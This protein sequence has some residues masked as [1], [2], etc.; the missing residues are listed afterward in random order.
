MASK[1]FIILLYFTFLS[2]FSY[3]NAQ[4]YDEIERDI[5]DYYDN[6]LDLFE[7]KH[8]V[9]VSG[10]C[11]DLSFYYYSEEIYYLLEKLK[12]EEKN[13]NFLK[14]PQ[15]IDVKL[16]DKL[17]ICND[18][19]I[20]SKDEDYTK[21]QNISELYITNMSKSPFD[22][23]NFKNLNT[24][25]LMPA[26][27]DFGGGILIN[28]FHLNQ[29]GNLNKLQNV[30]I[31]TQKIYKIPEKIA[32]LE[33]LKILFIK[34][35]EVSPFLSL[36]LLIKDV[37]IFDEALSRSLYITDPSS[38]S[39][40]P[41]IY[42]FYSV[43]ILDTTF[44]IDNNKLNFLQLNLKT[45]QKHNTKNGDFHLNYKNGNKLTIGKFKNGKPVGE[46]KFYY[47]NGN[48]YSIRKYKD[49]KE[50]G[51]WY[52]F[53]ETGDTTLVLKF[54]KGFLTYSLE[55]MDSIYGKEKSYR[56][57]VLEYQQETPKKIKLSIYYDKHEKLMAEFIFHE[58]Y[59]TPNDYLDHFF[60]DIIRYIIWKNEHVKIDNYKIDNYKMD[61]EYK[62]WD[63]NGKLVNDL[64]YKKGVLINK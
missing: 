17:A 55:K 4:E 21:Y 58:T 2:L 27:G 64:K 61:Y 47:P 30:V 5:D 26:I 32:E 52:K 28:N 15:G 37:K 60:F 63:V 8:F 40:T 18:Q 44:T 3:L 23:N 59:L 56:A 51:I 16:I 1:R 48:L 50:N 19:Y 46:W 39:L 22:F 49:G 34:G 12:R 10:N 20:K 13:I 29:I 62:F 57:E 25:Y 36:G 9:F 38:I 6:T 11:K 41:E 31:A 42:A 35:H 54:E 33:N 24:L 14:I 43:G 53:T 45:N 7:K